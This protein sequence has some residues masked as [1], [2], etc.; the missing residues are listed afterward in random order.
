MYLQKL[1]GCLFYMYKHS[2]AVDDTIQYN[3]LEWKGV[4]AETHWI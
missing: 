2:K 4:I 3:L 1:L